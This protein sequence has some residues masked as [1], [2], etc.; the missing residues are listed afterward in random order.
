MRVAGKNANAVTG[1]GETIHRLTLACKTVR[2]L[3]YEHTAVTDA[4]LLNSIREIDLRDGKFD[5]RVEAPAVSCERCERPN[6]PRRE[7]RIYCGDALPASLPLRQHLAIRDRN[8]RSPAP[9][10]SGCRP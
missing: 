8:A 2:E 5:G 3:L 6:S 10:R 9:A 4:D 1:I 7:P